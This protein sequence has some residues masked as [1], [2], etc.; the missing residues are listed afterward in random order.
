[1]ALRLAAALALALA[2]LPAGAV[3]PWDGPPFAAEPRALL[4][5]AEAL[6]APKGADVDV[7]LEEGTYRFD[8]R[9]AATF[10]HRLVY[11]PHAPDGARRW[12]RVERSWAPWYQARPE[13]RGRVVTPDGAVHELDP[14]TPSG[15][16]TRSEEHT[17]E[18]QS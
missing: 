8:A 2:A 7:L 18:L 10:T 1:M 3:A 6:G 13:V 9:G 12:A 17:S 14:A 16:T 5:A 15:V 11:R 4:A